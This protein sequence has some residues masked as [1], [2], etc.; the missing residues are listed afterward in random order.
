MK[1]RRANREKYVNQRTTYPCNTR[2]QKL[3]LTKIL[4]VCDKSNIASAKTIQKNGGILENGIESEGKIEQRY[5][6][7]L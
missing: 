5:W 4:M 7:T 2:V 3:G 6:I 1:T